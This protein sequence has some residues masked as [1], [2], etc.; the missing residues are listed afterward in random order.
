MV[1][2]FRLKILWINDQHIT[3]H[4]ANIVLTFEPSSAFKTSCARQLV[5]LSYLCSVRHSWWLRILKTLEFVLVKST[6]F[7]VKKQVQ[8]NYLLMGSQK[9]CKGNPWLFYI[10]FLPLEHDYWLCWNAPDTE[11][12]LSKHIKLYHYN[13]SFS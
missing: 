7:D 13:I 3:Q 9:T 5:V 2:K 1:C 6:Y 8:K 12:R 10:I 11:K 4:Y